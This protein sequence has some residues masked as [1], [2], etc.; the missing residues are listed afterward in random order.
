[1]GLRTDVIGLEAGSGLPIVTTDT[2]YAGMR[3]AMDADCV[4]NAWTTAAGDAR[5][6][7]RQSNLGRALAVRMPLTRRRTSIRM[8]SETDRAM[9][10]LQPE[11]PNE[12]PQ[13]LCRLS[14]VRR[15]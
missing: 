12:Q 9:P 14:Q 8:E 13:S 11:Y 5:V 6:F 7:C 2:A 10:I 3:C 15:P 1:M 4:R